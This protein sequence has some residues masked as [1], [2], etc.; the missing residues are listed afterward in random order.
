MRCFSPSGLVAG[1]IS[2][3]STR[4]EARERQFFRN[5]CKEM[6][7]SILFI[8]EDNHFL[9]VSWSNRDELL[10]QG[11]FDCDSR[12]RSCRY[13]LS[14]QP[15]NERAYQSKNVISTGRRENVFGMD[16]YC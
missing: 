1:V 8:G 7:I 12:F 10:C 6:G 3:Q 9:R 13:L 14:E 16:G 5:V 2:S 11:G 15:S 4:S